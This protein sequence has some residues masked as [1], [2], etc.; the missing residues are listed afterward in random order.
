MMQSESTQ[1]Y[2]NPNSRV[3]RTASVTE[4]PVVAGPNRCLFR[5]P[6][7]HWAADPAMTQ[8]Q[9]F[10]ELSAAF[11]E[12]DRDTICALHVDHSRG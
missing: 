11:T 5:D 2:C 3:T 4:E 1:R 10:A 12:P 6:G 8:G 7:W 9:I